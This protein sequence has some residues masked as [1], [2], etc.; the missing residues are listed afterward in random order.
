MG[1]VEAELTGSRPPALPLA[2]WP[3]AYGPSPDDLHLRPILRQRSRLLQHRASLLP[4]S[5]S[6]SVSPRSPTDPPPQVIYKNLGVN[7]VSRQ[8]GYNL[9]NAVVSA[10]SAVCGAALTDKMPRRKILVF[11]TFG[12]CYGALSKPGS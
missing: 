10:F 9:A 2:Q 5:L 8:L 4:L 7:S 1:D 11:G 12:E 3:L 6:L